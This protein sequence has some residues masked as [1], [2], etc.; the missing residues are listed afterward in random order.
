MGDRTVRYCAA[1]G[2]SLEVR[3]AFGRDRPTCPSCGWIH[4][5]DPK[6]AAGVLVEQDGK[7][8]LVRRTIEPQRGRWSLPAGFVDAGEDPRRAAEREA[9]EETGLEVEASTI[10]DLY[11]GREHPGG[12]DIVLIFLA[13]PR[14]GALRPGDDADAV[15]YFHPD[16]LPDL[17]FEATRRSLE[18]WRA[19]TAGGVM[20]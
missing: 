9:L 14:G 4:F 8:L 13:E 18:T 5:E 20:L 1:C 15:A 10:L 17:A 3:P 7:V 2:H 19:R 16:H 12:A 6:V 11:A